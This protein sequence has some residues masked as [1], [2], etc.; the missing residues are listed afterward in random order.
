[1]RQ[2]RVTIF[3][4]KESE[5]VSAPGL[6]YEGKLW[7][8]GGWNVLIGK[9]ERMPARLIRLDTLRLQKLPRG[10]EDDYALDDPMPKDV[11][12]GRTRQAAGVRYEVIEAPNIR[13]P[14]PH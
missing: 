8:V 9:Q 4:S 12:E 11:Y 10:A 2:F 14:L 5:I 1:M 7:L 3:F 13:L 6:E